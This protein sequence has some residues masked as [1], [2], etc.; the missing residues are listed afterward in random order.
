M[1]DNIHG[2]DVVIQNMK[3]LD[4]ENI[5]SDEII[6]KLYKLSENEIEIINRTINK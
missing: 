2:R 5:T 1:T 3:I 6:Y 4:L